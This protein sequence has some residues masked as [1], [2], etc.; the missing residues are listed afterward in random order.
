MNIPETDDFINV[1]DHGAVNEPGV[2]TIDNIMVHEGRE[3]SRSTG[4]TYSVGAHP[5]YLDEENVSRLLLKVK[6]FSRHLNVVAIGESGFDRLRGPDQ[7][8]QLQSFNYHARLA[9]EVGKPLFVHCVR[10]W[11][12]IVSE[13]KSIHPSVPW[14]VH[15]F[16]GKPEL[17]KQ[18]IDRGFYLSA[19]V[20]WAIRPESSETLKTIPV[21]RLFLETDGF[22]ISIKPVYEVV[23]GHI[24][25]DTETLRKKMLENYMRVFS[26][27]S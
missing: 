1:H 8:L 18:L 10:A 22:D 24:G 16:R 15:G 4:I 2:F 26:F 14:I 11:D 17:A 9:E 5:W 19:W 3:P 25:T 23:A 7:K 6:D 13:H 21:D 12:D 20:E 27:F